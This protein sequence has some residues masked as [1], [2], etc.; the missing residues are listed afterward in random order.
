MLV[1]D[2]TMTFSP[3]A[4][5]IECSSHVDMLSV[6]QILSGHIERPTGRIIDEGEDF[7]PV[8]VGDPLAPAN[9]LKESGRCILLMR[10]F[11]DEVELSEFPKVGWECAWSRN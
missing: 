4:I 3:N 1:A 9:L 6:I 7:D 2:C 8:E 10:D 11:M 5:R